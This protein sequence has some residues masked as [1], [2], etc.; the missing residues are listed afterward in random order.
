MLISQLVVD[1]FRQFFGRIS[2]DFSTD[3]EKNIT[4]IHGANGS[5]KTSLLNAFKWCF[6]GETDFDTSDEHILNEAAIESQKD[7]GGIEVRIEVKFL[8]ERKRYSAI[9]AQKFKKNSGLNAIPIESSSFVLDVTNE[10]GE[11]R[12]SP[13]ASLELESILPPDLQPYFFFNGERIEHIAGVNQSLQVQDA[14]K[15]LMGLEMVERGITHV[16]KAKNK[17]RKEVRD[18][19]TEDEQFY[20]DLIQNNEDEISNFEGTIKREKRSVELSK[21]KIVTIER[22]LKKFER[23]RELQESRDTLDIEFNDS[24]LEDKRLYAQQKEAINEQA[25]LVLSEEMFDTSSELIESNRKKGI[26]PYGI[27]EQFI[28]DRIELGNCICGTVFEVDSKE[29]KCL[30][31]IRKSSGSNSLESAYTTVSSSIKNYNGIVDK[32]QNNYTQMADR[33]G[34]LKSKKIKIEQKMEDISSQLRKV[35]DSNIVSLERSNKKEIES[36]DN[37]KENIG[38]AKFAK[39]NEELELKQNRIMHER[40]MEQ[41]GRRFISIQRMDKAEAMAKVL[42][43]LRDSLSAQVRD[44]LSKKVDSTFQSVIRKPVRAIID[45]DYK[46]QVL[47]KTKAGVEYVVNEQSTGERQVTSLSFIASIIALSKQKHEAGN[48]QFFQGGL[49]PL[50]MD[51]PF[52]SLDE[53]YR[54]K[55][56][57]SVSELAEQIIM[58]VSDSQWNGRVKEACQDRVGKSY[59][60]VYHSPKVPDNPNGYV[61]KSNNG[62]EFS[63]IEGSSL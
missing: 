53:E 32:F 51:S 5:G 3:S 36:R 16:N 1:N 48:N 52:G 37:A 6:Y 14:I 46:L 24:D 58:F 42:N 11:T 45:E 18:E 33:I 21:N 38:A 26:L 62:F 50:V 8:H 57:S 56:A 31:E 13:G 63:T 49:Y 59:Q 47:K 30:L 7:G 39:K 23:S 19:A 55:V 10:D 9:R 29:H 4:V 54:E 44:D 34:L 15:K 60:L 17:Y 12:R 2:L 28:D 22:E 35:D 40:I 27:N 25:F 20:L 61:I 43:E 41:S